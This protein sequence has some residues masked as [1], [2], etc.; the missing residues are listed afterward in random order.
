[1]NWQNK[2]FIEFLDAVDDLLEARYGITSNDT[3]LESIAVSQEAGWTPEETVD[4]IGNKYELERK[5]L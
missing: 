4:W 5:Q 2:S 3:N 1:M